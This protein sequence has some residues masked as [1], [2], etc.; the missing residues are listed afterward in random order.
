MQ[1]DKLKETMKCSRQ[2][3]DGPL[4]KVYHDRVTLPNG[5]ETGRDL[6]RHVG[7]V[8]IVPVTDDGKVVMERQY[9]YP[10]AQV[11]VEIPAGK[12][13]FAGEDRLKAAMRELREETGITADRWQD[14]GIYYPSPAYTDEKITMYLAQGLHMGGKQDLDEDEFLDFDL[15]DIKDVVKDIMDGKLTDGKTQVAIL[16][17]ARILGY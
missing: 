10:V 8:C 13:D 12:L 7:A 9:R 16:K 4:L 17:A 14:M 11:A 1:E 6:I 15:Q 5:S 3:Y 2:V